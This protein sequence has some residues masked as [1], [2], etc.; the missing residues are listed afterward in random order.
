MSMVNLKTARAEPVEAW[1][2]FYPF[3]CRIQDER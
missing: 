2:V 3:N 1:A